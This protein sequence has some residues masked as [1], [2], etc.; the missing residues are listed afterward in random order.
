MSRKPISLQKAE[1][2][3]RISLQKKDVKDAPTCAVGLALDVSGSMDTNYR[4]GMVSDVVTRMLALAKTFDDNGE[5][6]MWIFN[7]NSKKLDNATEDNYERFVEE[8]IIDAG[9]LGGGTTYS[10]CFKNIND[11][12]FPT[13][14]NG[15]PVVTKTVDVTTEKKVPVTTT[16][17]V[18]KSG[19]FGKLFGSKE[20]KTVTEYRI[21]TITE[22]KVV[23]DEEA[24]ANGEI[25]PAF[26]IFLTDGENESGDNARANQILQKSEKNPI[27]WLMVGVGKDVTKFDFIRNVANS[28]PNAA[29][30]QFDN[31]DIDDETLY[32][33][34]I[35]QKFI[36][37]AESV[38]A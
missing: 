37:W 21:E 19:L 25:N 6:D 7:N 33:N 26:V 5:M 3:V 9:N 36:D 20:T 30:L 29:Y 16:V 15:H 2:K 34:A 8:Q 18:P 4:T 24:T 35:S 27:F 10:P 1:E 14:G 11:F 31:L 28:H 13:D 23:I 38:K 22:K 17:E 12:Y 32:D